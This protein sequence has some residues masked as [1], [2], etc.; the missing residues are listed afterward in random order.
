MLIICL[1]A[2]FILCFYIFLIWPRLSK[3][4][5]M[6]KYQGTCFAH[7]GYHNIKL[8]IPENSLPAFKRALKCGYA[9]E[10]DLHLTKDRQLIVFHDDNLKRVCN[11]DATP[12]SLTYEELLKLRLLGTNERIPLFSEVL[13]L[14][15]GKV[16][17]LVELK[18]G[19]TDLSLCPATYEALKDYPGEYLV[20]SFNPL[21]LGWFKRHAPEVL[22]GQLS[23]NMRTSKAALPSV[24]K[25][26]LTRLLTNVIARPDFVS[27]NLRYT[28]RITTTLMRRLFGLP[29]AVWTLRDEKSYRRGRD[30]FEMVIFEDSSII[31]KK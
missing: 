7:R 25:F 28:K 14:I 12:E 2:L 30:E 22:R 17:L 4:H 16:P 6:K 5:L 27:Y 29:Y 9:I 19:G 31:M 11:L 13:G 3:S 10:L 24:Y 20:Q 18:V 1:S 23:S 21:A 15:D 8:G 26:T